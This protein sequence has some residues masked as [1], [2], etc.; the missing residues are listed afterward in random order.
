MHTNSIVEH[1]QLWW[2]VRPHH[3]FGTV[4]FRICDAQS[5]A[6]ASTALAGMITACVAQAAIDHDDGV[7][8]EDPPRRLVEE[9]FW[10]AIRYGLDGKLIDLERGEEFPAAVVTDRLLAWT[11]P[12]RA[13]LGVEAALPSENGAQRQRRGG[14]GS[15]DRG[16]IRCRACRGP[17][18]LCRSGSEELSVHDEMREPTEEE[19]RAA[20]EEQMR[21]I[22]VE[23]VVLQSVATLVNLAGRRLELGGTEE[24]RDLPQA[25]LAIDA[26]RAL[27]PMCPPD[28]EEAIRQA[29]YRRCRWRTRGRRSR[30]PTVDGR[31]G[32]RMKSGGRAKPL[33]VPLSRPGRP[34][35]PKARAKIWTP[36]G[37]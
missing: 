31:P 12:A 35:A 19:L 26:A 20:M 8:F 25:K 28:Q 7:A 24:E 36:P 3:S 11:A 13:A 2:S 27:A 9:N 1:T 30:Q 5:S 18:D 33:G 6:D 34:S 15:V 29:R 10:R 32:R 17:T 16:G 21:R 22:R 23:D 37:A 14:R 4:E